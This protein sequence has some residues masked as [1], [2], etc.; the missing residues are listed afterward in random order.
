MSSRDLEQNIS[1]YILVAAVFLVAAYNLFNYG[2][3]GKIF[4]LL[5]LSIATILLIGIVFEYFSEEDEIKENVRKS[6]KM[7]IYATIAFIILNIII[8]YGMFNDCLENYI[9][10]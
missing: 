5:T 10:R 8:I 7:L 1:E 6:I 3:N 4:S 9:M 2:E